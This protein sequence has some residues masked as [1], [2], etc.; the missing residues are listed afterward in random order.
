MNYAE[1]IA[2]LDLAKSLIEAIKGAGILEPIIQIETD[3]IVLEW[4]LLGK[5]DYVRCDIGKKII[6][7][8]HSSKDFGGRFSPNEHEAI[9][10][11]IKE[12]L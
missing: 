3:G 9:I 5:D 6:N 10:N 8:F 4:C 2:F 11:K 12:L 7:V 1:T